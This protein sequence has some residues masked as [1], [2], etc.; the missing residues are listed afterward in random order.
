M[1]SH[2]LFTVKGTFE[3]AVTHVERIRRGAAPS[4]EVK[5]FLRLVQVENEL[6]VAVREKDS[7]PQPRMPAPARGSDTAGP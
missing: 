4:V 3:K 2:C 5:G 1:L 6:E 7:A